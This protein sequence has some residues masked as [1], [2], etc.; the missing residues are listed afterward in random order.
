MMNLARHERQQ[1]RDTGISADD[2]HV[3][4]Y[5]YDDLRLDWKPVSPRLRLYGVLK[6]VFTHAGWEGDGAIEYMD[7]PPFCADDEQN[8]NG[9]WFR[10]YHVKQHNDGISYLASIRKLAQSKCLS[11]EILT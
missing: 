4:S 7:L 1:L 8:G 3:Y 6:Q 5:Y 2:L 11:L 9:W 10:V